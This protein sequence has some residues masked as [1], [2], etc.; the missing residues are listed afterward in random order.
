MRVVFVVDISG[1]V[2]HYDL[3]LCDALNL[4]REDRYSIYLLSPLYKEDNKNNTLRLCNLV[5]KKY[6]NSSN[7]F[8]RL[9]KL[10]ELILNYLLLIRY[11][12]KKRPE[13]LHFQWFPLL[14]VSSMEQIP[15]KVIR[16]ISPNIKILYT[17]HN[18]FPHNYAE[19]KKEIYKLRF[20]KIANYI[21]S[22]I[23]HTNQTKEEVKS[24]YCLK[25]SCIKV[26][27]HGIFSAKGFIPNKNYLS[28]ERVEFIIFG[29][30]S[31]YKGV[32]IFIDAFRQLPQDYLNHV[33]GVI[34]GTLQDET[35]I[36]K[37]QEEGDKL[38][39]ECYPYYLS[40]NDLYQ[41]INKSN[42][43][44]LPYRQI[45]QSGVLLLS[46]RFRRYII[47]S[48]LPTF[49]ETLRGFTEDMFFQSSNPQSLANL[50][51]RIVDG[52][53]D[54]RLQEKVI[55]EL[56]TEYS[57]ENSAIKTLTIYNEL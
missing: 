7:S 27:N 49:K 11:V 42:V 45:S 6:M 40:D 10:I 33:H 41:L 51:M 8:K 24:V 43:I 34:A 22:F 37:I 5:P 31:K 16:R 20:S 15:I 17:I 9:L 46:L 14:E 19:G 13:I 12:V 28:K 30:L 38:N 48:D 21:D 56:N 25:D 2:S 4:R 50:I 35:I 26:V 47:T 44:V 36:K 29:S 53:F 1:K 52:K 39:I 57:W 54:F 32:D 55:E 23:V 18:V 3:E